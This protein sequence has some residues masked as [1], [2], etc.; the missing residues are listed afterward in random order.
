MSKADEADD[1]HDIPPLVPDRDDVDTHLRNKRAQ[2]QQIVRPGQQPRVVNQAGSWPMRIVTGLLVVAA[3]AGGYGAWH[4]QQLYQDN[5]RQTNLRI[6]DLELRLA[7]VDQS[8]TESDNTLMENIEQTIEQYDLLWANWR[9]NNRMFE[10][11]QGEIARLELANQGQDEIASNTSQLL[12]NTGQTVQAV[13][14]RL[15]RLGQQMSE[16][17][18]SISAIDGQVQQL[19]TMRNDLA[20][21]R[22]ALDSGDST[23]L[24]LVGRLEYIEESMESVNAHRLQINQTLF[25]LQESIEALQ[26]SVLNASGGS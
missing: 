9:A 14:T 22:Q 12:A 20:S 18:Q 11:I 10:E 17:G 3:V 26:R 6:S 15:N 16:L 7:L 8:A 21:I 1:L 2:R 4:F 13:Q 23:V 19:G 5:L 24:G 25:R